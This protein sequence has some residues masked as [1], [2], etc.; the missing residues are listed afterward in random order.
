MESLS[1]ERREDGLV[2]MPVTMSVELCEIGHDLA[3]PRRRTLARDLASGQHDDARPGGVGQQPV[4]ALPTHETGCPG[5]E[6]DRAG[7]QLFAG[8]AKDG[9][10]IFISVTGP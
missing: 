6:R 2:R 4:Q 5:D 10:V 7:R 3:E 1:N 8:G 9:S